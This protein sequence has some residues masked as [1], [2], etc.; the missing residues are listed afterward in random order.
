MLK[1]FFILSSAWKKVRKD[2]TVDNIKDMTLGTEVYYQRDYPIL[3]KQN[4]YL[5]IC[6]AE[7]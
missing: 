5:L 6:F 4:V 3:P 1:T 7:N 2:K